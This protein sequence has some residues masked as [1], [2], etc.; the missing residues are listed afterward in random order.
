[1][2]RADVVMQKLEALIADPAATPGEREAAR[3]RIEA[4]KSK[5]RLMTDAEVDAVIDVLTADVRQLS[6]KKE[7]LRLYKA[8]AARRWRQKLKAMTDAEFSAATQA[9]RRH[10]TWRRSY[11]TREQWKRWKKAARAMTGDELREAQVRFPRP[12]RH[13][14]PTF[15]TFISAELDH[16]RFYGEPRR[17]R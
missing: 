13:M 4:I 15:G 14:P 17:R 9:E 3:A 8:E 1:M 7:E 12:E 10:P 16:R 2:S 5:Y 6:R 11:V